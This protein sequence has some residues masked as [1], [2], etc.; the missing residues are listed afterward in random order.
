MQRADDALGD[1]A[2]QTQ[3]R[4]GGQHLVADAN[5]V[6]VTQPGHRQVVD[7]V[8][9]EHGQVG[10]RVA[11]DQVG[12]N[13]LAVVEHHGGLELARVVGRFGDDVVVG[14]DVAAA[15]D[16]ESGALHALLVADRLDRHYRISHCR[17][18]FG[19]ST[20]RRFAVAVGRQR[21]L[22]GG[23]RL[24]DLSRL[25]SDHAADHADQQRQHGEHRKRQVGHPPAEQHVTHAEPAARIAVAVRGGT[26]HR[27]VTERGG[28]T[29]IAPGILGVLRLVLAF[30]VVER[31]RVGGVALQRIGSRE[32]PA[33][34]LRQYR[35]GGLGRAE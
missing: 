10:L 11:A 7:V 33:E 2:A 6:G 20:G 32:R 17:S 3:R 16:D 29:G 8:D 14:D 21:H 22:G 31:A 25:A 34:S 1:G 28:R 9:L 4:T 30:A 23:E 24:D 35:V 15:V 13:F 5:L 27:R 12:R 26:R 19:E 18:H